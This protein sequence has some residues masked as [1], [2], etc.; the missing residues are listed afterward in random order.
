MSQVTL[1]PLDEILFEEEP[2]TYTFRGKRIESVTQV[3]RKAG[4]GDDFSAV[5]QDRM[6]YAQRRGKMVHLACQYYDENCLDLA[7]VDPA[8]QG[9]VEAYIRFRREKKLNVVAVEKRLL[10]T[11]SCLVPS[12]RHPKWKHTPTLRAS[13]Q[14]Q[15]CPCERFI[16]GVDLAGTPDLVCFMD[17]HRCVIDR[18][19][20]QIMAK[21]MGLQ[22]QG[23]A[24]L[25]NLLHPTEPIRK[26]FGLRL[27]KTGKYKLM[28]HDDLDDARSFVDCMEYAKAQNRI[29]H[30]RTIYA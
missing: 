17:G 29:D 9:Y 19:T 2:H 11:E 18:K 20:S 16:G 28:P 13:C 25:W 24:Y 30:W 10:S 22:T 27:E 8:I 6:A 1:L 23:Y 12:C 14:E 7:T 15:K 4:L 3:I 21:S 26:R 5:P